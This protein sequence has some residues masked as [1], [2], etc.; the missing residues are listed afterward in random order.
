MAD[1]STVEFWLYTVIEDT[2]TKLL[3]QVDSCFKKAHAAPFS[4][5]LR[6]LHIPTIPF[7]AKACVNSSGESYSAKTSH[8]AQKYSRFYHVRGI[9]RDP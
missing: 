3:L 6:I 9:D 2:K 5:S 1:T 4:A 8:T 7:E